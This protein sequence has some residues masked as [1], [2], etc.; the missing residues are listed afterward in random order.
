MLSGNH[1]GDV[2]TFVCEDEADLI[3]D[4]QRECRSNGRWSGK[5]PQC[6]CEQIFR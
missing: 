4:N 2:A 3:G 6:L 5:M 1:V